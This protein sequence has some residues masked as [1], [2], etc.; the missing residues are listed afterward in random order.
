MARG[1]QNKDTIM[2]KEL[3]KIVKEV[4]WV[5]HTL[6]TAEMKR[7]TECLEAKKPQAE[8]EKDGE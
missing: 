6:N 5:G 2:S 4:C 8:K 1:L 3:E 7:I